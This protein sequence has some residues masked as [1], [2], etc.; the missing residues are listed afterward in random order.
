[1]KQHFDY[2]WYGQQVVYTLKLDKK[3]R[4]M[5]YELYICPTFLTR[6]TFMTAVEVGD[7][8]VETAL[9]EMKRKL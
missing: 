4:D 2:F 7:A 8:Q 5:T 6:G 1:M 9:T 3:K